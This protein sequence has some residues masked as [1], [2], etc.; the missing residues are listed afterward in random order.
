MSAPL[1]YRKRLFT[2]SVDDNE[3]G[4]AAVVCMD[5]QN[6]TVCWRYSLRGS[7]R[8]SIAIADGLVFAQDVHGYLYAIQAETGTL[9][10]EKDLNIGVLH[11]LNDGLVAVSDIVYAGTGKSLCALKAATGELIWKNGAWSRGEGC[12]AT[13][14]LGHSILIGHANWKGLYANNAVNGE[15]LWENKD[16]ELKYRSAS[17][18][19]EGENLYL[20]S[21]RSFF[22]LNSKNGEIIVRKKLNCSVNVNST[23]LVTGSEIIF[24]T[25]T[26]GVIALDKQT[27]EEKWNFKT[28]PALIYTS[29]Y[30]KPSSS[31]VETSPVLVGDT[32]FFGASDGILYALNRINGKLLWKYQTG[33]PI[34]STVSIAGNALYVTDFAG[35]VYGF[36]MNN[37]TQ[38]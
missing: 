36:I 18:A 8:S 9:V 32:I 23:P 7:V 35:N 10:W 19:W 24:G 20:L 38:D 16:A 37:K 26:N 28:N 22:I 33:V 15:L 29:P 25:A 34:F 17:V 31:T 2:A 11:P 30:S 14:S 6:G 21:S 1:V 13:L 27:L 12:V 4:K 5:A 3:S